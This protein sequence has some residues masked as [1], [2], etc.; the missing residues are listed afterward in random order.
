MSSMSMVTVVLAVPSVPVVVGA[1]AVV[2][3]GL[4]RTAATTALQAVRCL[5]GNG[6][7]R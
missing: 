2:G 3:V 6:G 1:G 5:A 4:G 7:E